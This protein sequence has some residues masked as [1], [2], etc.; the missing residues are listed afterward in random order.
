M[1]VYCQY[2]TS[3]SYL[4][5]PLHFYIHSYG[6]VVI[7]SEWLVCFHTSNNWEMYNFSLDMGV[8]YFLITAAPP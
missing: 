4:F 1:C 6:V 8:Q 2:F 3:L 5:P 7:A